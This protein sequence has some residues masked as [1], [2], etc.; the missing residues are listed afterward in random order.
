MLDE[1]DCG[2]LVDASLDMWLTAGRYAA[3]FEKE[4]AKKFGSK[5]AKLTVSG[6][7]LISL[8]SRP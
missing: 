3:R 8:H 4:L 2:L 6:S 1:D 7:A 5:L